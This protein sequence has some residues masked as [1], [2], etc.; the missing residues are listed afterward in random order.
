MFVDLTGGRGLVARVGGDEFVIMVSGAGSREAASG[1]AQGILGF[2]GA[3]ITVDGGAIRITASVGAAHRRGADVSAMELLKRADTAMYEAKRR[4][5]NS[6]AWYDRDVG[7]M[8]KRE[9]DRAAQLR[10]VLDSQSV[11][12]NYCAIVEAASEEIVGVAAEPQWEIAGQEFD[13]N[14]LRRLVEENDLARPFLAAVLSKAFADALPWQGIRLN[15]RL[16][17][18]LVGRPDFA[19]TVLEAMSE[20]GFPAGRLTIEIGE[21]DIAGTALDDTCAELRARGIALALRGFGDGQSSIGLL[22]RTKFAELALDPSLAASIVIDG[23]S[24]R[25][26][27]G[28][29]ALAAALELSVTARGVEDGDQAGLLRL[30]G[31]TRLEGPCFG[32]EMTAEA[33]GRALAEKRISGAR[34]TVRR[35]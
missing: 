5:G 22:Q 1:I 26:S 24:Q 29:V 28:M 3:P 16:P 8:R 33:V 4:G 31:C 21:A 6:H 19:A 10:A 30:A 18:A 13:G 9:R 35:H 7:Q 20:T 25:L 12:L 2:F 23:N 15:M 34:K 32:D 14:E 11:K 17:G 27:Q